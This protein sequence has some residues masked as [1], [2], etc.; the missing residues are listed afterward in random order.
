MGGGYVGW[1]VYQGFEI[2]AA[3][4]GLRDGG[5]SHEG[6]LIEHRGAT[7]RETKFFA[8]GSSATRDS[9]VEAIIAEGKRLVDFR[10]Q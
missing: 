4:Y 1:L 8:G 9:A 10:S 5:W 3:P 2:R 7:T 6:Y